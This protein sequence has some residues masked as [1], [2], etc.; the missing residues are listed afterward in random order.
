MVFAPT[1]NPNGIDN[2]KVAFAK[3]GEQGTYDNYL[4]GVSLV[5]KAVIIGY[6][7]LKKDS[8]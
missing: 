5:G 4:V 6:K 2:F 7:F 3:E 1:I 8:S